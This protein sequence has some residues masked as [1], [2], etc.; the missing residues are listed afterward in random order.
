MLLRKALDIGTS[1]TFLNRAL[2]I[3]LTLENIILKLAKRQ[4]I[5]SLVQLILQLFGLNEK[6]IKKMV[7]VGWEECCLYVVSKALIGFF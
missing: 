6:K 2:P 1:S 7:H 3:A 4:E 5:G